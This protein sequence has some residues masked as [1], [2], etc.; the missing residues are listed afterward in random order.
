MKFSL[1]ILPCYRP[2]IAPTLHQ[3]Y[4]EL[5]ETVRL[6]DRTGWDRAWVSEHHFHYYGGASPNPAML[7]QAWSRETRRIRLGTGIVLLPLNHPLRT[8]EDYAVLD[9]MSGGRLDFGVGRGYLP[10][11][12]AGFNVTQDATLGKFDEALD[13]VTKAWSGEP[14][15]YDGVHY[16]FGRLRVEPQPMQ[17]PVPLWVACSRSKDSFEAAG[18]DGAGL[19]MNQYP[20]SV[21]QMKERFGWYK[22]A[23]AAAGHDPQKRNAMMAMF[24]NIADSEEQAIEEAKLGV[25]EHANL[26]R[27]LFGGDQWNTDYVGDES[28]FRFL[29]PDGDVTS[30]FRERT[31]VGTVDQICER[32]AFYRDQGYSEMSFIVRY[33]TLPHSKALD[34]IDRVNRLI[35]PRFQARAAA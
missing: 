32:I 9:Q 16:K 29:Q 8:A 14:F 27:L 17:K 22:D 23:Y 19:L 1:F 7:L 26:F 24:L 15:A 20:M 18:R 28:V 4:E 3:F 33:G 21:A 34:N 2:G 5:S 10:H 6:A 30:L 35:R 12:F 31:L 11:E 25:Q 13:I